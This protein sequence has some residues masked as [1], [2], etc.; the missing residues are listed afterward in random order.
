MRSFIEITK[1]I[2]RAFHYNHII[3]VCT[4]NIAFINFSLLL[5]SI[6]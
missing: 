4:I 3:V 2:K 1:L 5:V 6:F